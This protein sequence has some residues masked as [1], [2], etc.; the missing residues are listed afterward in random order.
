MFKRKGDVDN[1]TE[2]FGLFLVIANNITMEENRIFFRGVIYIHSI[3]LILVN[4]IKEHMK[5]NENILIHLKG[6]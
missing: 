5:D 2:K 1:N 4:S 3:K 6:L